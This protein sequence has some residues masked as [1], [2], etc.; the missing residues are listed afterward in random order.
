MDVS[1]WEPQLLEL[2][3]RG[4]PSATKGPGVSIIKG[5]SG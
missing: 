2:Q 4:V 3:S 1:D 5:S